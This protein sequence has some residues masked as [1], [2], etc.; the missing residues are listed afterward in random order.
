MGALVTMM[1][2]QETREN[3]FFEKL[4]YS[5][6]E[7]EDFRA[8]FTPEERELYMKGYH[9]LS[10]EE[11]TVY[12]RAMIR[13]QSI[14]E[15]DS[16]YVRRRDE[17]IIEILRR[18]FRVDLLNR[19]RSDPQYTEIKITQPA[20]D[21][22]K[23]IAA[24]MCELSNDPD[25]IYMHLLTG[26]DDNDH[27]VRDAYIPFQTVNP[28]HC[29]IIPEKDHEDRSMISSRRK[30]IIGWAHSHGLHAL[31]HSPDD[32]LNLKRLPFLYGERRTIFLDTYSS[33]NPQKFDIYLLPSVI[34]NK[35]GDNPS[36]AISI[37]YCDFPEFTPH[38]HIN[39][40]PT[41][42]VIG[43]QSSD[44]DIGEIDRDILQRVR[45]RGGF[46]ESLP[47]D[48][49]EVDYEALDL[50]ELLKEVFRNKHRI[51]SLEDRVSR[52]EGFIN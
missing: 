45:N 26:L 30:K 50:V 11:K 13:V 31:F 20:F 1:L 21:K 16:E 51:N 36:L 14:A 4:G 42:R 9:R 41:L 25:E 17:R 29:D 10:A 18:G 37:E 5:P 33:A 19:F 40:R 12:N 49:D 3:I 24:R 47:E 15:S 28:S 52:L 44:I 35:R 7:I 39:E 43:E 2:P 22:V 32:R 38:I 27:V 46:K 6:D 48:S 34:V 8:K 23:L